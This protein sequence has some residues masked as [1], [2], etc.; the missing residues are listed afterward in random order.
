MRTSTVSAL[1]LVSFLA[2]GCS[3]DASY[4]DIELLPCPPELF[5]MHDAE[6]TYASSEE[7]PAMEPGPAV[8][9]DADAVADAAPARAKIG[10]AF[11]EQ[12]VED[13]IVADVPKEDRRPAAPAVE[14]GFAAMGGGV[15]TRAPSAPSLRSPEGVPVKLA[16]IDAP[17]PS[18]AVSG[19]RAKVV[20]E[21]E[22]PVQALDE[23]TI[24]KTVRGQMP[25]IRA[26]YERVIKQDPMA[27]GKIVMSWTITADGEVRGVRVRDDEVGN[28]QFQGCAVRSVAK[29]RF[30]KGVESVSVTYPFLMAPRSY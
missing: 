4:A 20:K 25:R 6:W 28:E 21:P 2:F 15:V 8:A 24:A 10:V 19:A 11:F 27:R 5:S 22:A 9:S 14:D 17:S 16:M 18:G 23:A 7:M 12:F 3:R 13:V 26:C 1:A 30:P 29:W